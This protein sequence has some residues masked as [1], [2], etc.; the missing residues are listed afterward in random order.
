MLCKFAFL[1]GKLYLSLS[2]FKAAIVKFARRKGE[3]TLMVE[4]ASQ[5]IVQIGLLTTLPMVIEIGLERGFRTALGD[6]I[7]MQ[8]QLAPVFFTFSLGTKMHYFGCTL[9]HGGAKYRATGMMYYQRALKLQAFLDMANEKEI[10]DGY[11]VVTVPSEEDKKSH[12]SLYASLEAAADMKFTYIATCQNYGNQK[13]SGDRRATDILNLMVNNPSL[14]VA[15]IDEVEEREGGKVQK[16]YYS[17]LVKAVDN[18][19]Q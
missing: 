6:F 15:F 4:I 5:S 12:R 9:L 10:L 19:D 18:H 3:D 17:V 11:K 8:L 16:V 1:Y 14:R 13:R 7:I 2:G